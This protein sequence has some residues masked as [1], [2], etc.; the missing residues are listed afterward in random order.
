M[1]INFVTCFGFDFLRFTNKIDSFTLKRSIS[2]YFPYFWPYD[3]KM[4]SH[5]VFL[6][7]GEKSPAQLKGRKYVPVQPRLRIWRRLISACAQKLCAC[8]VRMWCYFF[9]TW[10][11]ILLWTPVCDIV[12]RLPIWFLSLG[13]DEQHG[14]SDLSL[15]D[16]LY[17][18]MVGGTRR[19]VSR[20]VSGLS[21]PLFWGSSWLI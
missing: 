3:S 2:H 21:L 17:H 6:I 4:S 11:C 13:D 19:L 12:L 20:Y 8:V 16:Q 7:S 10:D 1:K 5:Q 15:S 18:F 14:L 9:K